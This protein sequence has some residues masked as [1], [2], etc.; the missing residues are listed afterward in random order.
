MLSKHGIVVN[1]VDI[2]SEAMTV[3]VGGGS[4]G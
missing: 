2:F 1:V 3:S 4:S